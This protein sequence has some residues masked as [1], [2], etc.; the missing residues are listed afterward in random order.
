MMIV[1]AGRVEPCERN[2]TTLSGEDKKVCQ[3][4]T[5]SN[6]LF[7]G[8]HSLRDGEDHEVCRAVLLEVTVD[9]RL[10]LEDVGV[11]DGALG[12]ESGTQRAETVE[13]LGVA[14]LRRRSLVLSS[15][16]L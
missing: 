3:S 12:D 6:R 16:N 1:P 9:V 4:L 2:E 14:P 5:L 10:E 13:R 7:D 8:R 15:S 11:G